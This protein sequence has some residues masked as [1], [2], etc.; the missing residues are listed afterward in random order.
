MEWVDRSNLSEIE[1][2]N[3]LEYKKHGIGK[4]Y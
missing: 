1:T 4:I 3:D 2:V